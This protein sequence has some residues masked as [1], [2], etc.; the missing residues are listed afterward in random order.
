MSFTTPLALLLLLTIP[1]AIYLGWPRYA[2]RRRRDSASL[3]L[4]VVI[5][6]LVIL[7]LAG[8]QIVGAVD[9]MAVIF[10][11]DVSDSMGPALRAEQLNIIRQAVQNKPPEDIWAIVAFGANPVVEQSFTTVREVNPLRSTVVTTHTNIAAAIQTAI[12]MFPSDARRRIVILSDGQATLGDARAKAQLAAAAGIE[13]SYIH[14]ARPPAPDVLITDLDAPNRVAQGQEFDLNVTID[15]EVAT[16]ATLRIFSR[17]ELIY[18]EPINLRVGTN[19]YTLSQVSTT[20]GFLDF[21]AQIVVDDAADN[22]RQNNRLAA[23]SQVVGPPRILLVA[24]DDQEIA[25]LTAALLQNDAQLETI[26]PQNLPLS[27]SE[28]ASYRAIVLANVPATRLSDPQMTTLDRYVKDLGGGLIVIG[29]PEAYGPGGYFQRPIER[30]L[31]VEMQIKDQQRLPQLTIAYLIDRSGSMGMIGPS[32]VPNI[33]LAKEAIIRSIDFLQPT[34]RAG[35]A[36]FDVDGSWVAELQDIGDRRS[37]Q[38]FVATLRSGGGTDIMAGMQLV[39]GSITEEPSIRKHIILMTDGG[40]SPSGLIELTESLNRDFGVTTS[41]IAIGVQPPAFLEQMAQA[42]GGN[43]HQVANIQDIPTIF[44]LETVLASR[45]YIVEETF[46]PTLTANNPIMDGITALPPLRGYVAT[47]PKAAAQIVLSGPE[48][49]RDPLLAAW[50]YGLGRVVA[51]TSDA[52]ARWAAD[53]VL[54]SDFPRFWSQAISWSLT[55]GASANLETQVVMEEQNARI[56][57]NARTPTGDFLNGLSLEASVLSPDSE[58]T[59]LR[60]Q[61]VAPGRYEALFTPDDEGAYYLAVNGTGDLGGDPIAFN[62]VSGWVMSYSPEYQPLGPVDDRLLAEL[63]DITNGRSLAEDLGSMF[64]RTTETRAAATPIWPLLLALALL[65]LPLDIAVRRLVI[66]PSDWARLRAFLFG[67]A[68]KLASSER[69]SSLMSARERARQR[70]E[71]TA[72]GVATVANLRAS[73]AERNMTTTEALITP[74]PEATTI[75]S[76]PPAP[77]GNAPSADENIGARL[78]KKRRG[79]DDNEPSRPS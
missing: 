26:T 37:L 28:L 71:E 47:T 4:R 56:I 54:W 34:D 48:P 11:V 50:Q 27:I 65:L 62:A 9:R 17:G 63:A 18:E 42:G 13:I 43:Y 30:M 69:L 24:T 36:S 52:T 74:P 29:G 58:G 41:T 12:G 57:V 72:S 31:P 76:G 1:L 10:L 3:L 73:K 79:R 16:T 61:Q 60:L 2:F 38:R 33:E 75:T 40:A 15:A 7:A 21:S 70:V 25:Q 35:I 44:A 66:T 6:L 23:F 49:F 51:F 32:G 53:W 19:R 8:A 55:E 59:S 14:L 68:P 67:R 77:K 78:L 5:L 46:V 45:T 22:F 64:N 20:S 39:A